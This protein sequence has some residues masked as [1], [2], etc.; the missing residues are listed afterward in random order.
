MRA[1]IKGKANQVAISPN[2]ID[3]IR[4]DSLEQ[5][6]DSERLYPREQNYPEKSY[7][8][9]EHDLRWQPLSTFLRASGPIQC[10][11]SVRRP[12]KNK[13]LIT[14]WLKGYLLFAYE[15]QTSGGM[16]VLYWPAAYFVRQ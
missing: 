11:A 8:Y 6:E 7:S 5:T 1:I 4:R 9:Q 13:R 15:R 16:A 12:E 3:N 14:T 2:S 10:K